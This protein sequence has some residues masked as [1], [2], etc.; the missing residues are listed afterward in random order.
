MSTLFIAKIC[1]C[2]FGKRFF[3]VA[4]TRVT[5]VSRQRATVLIYDQFQS[6]VKDQIVESRDTTVGPYSQRKLSV[7]TLITRSSLKFSKSQVRTSKI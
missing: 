3:A 5:T 2:Y 1:F 6:T 4:T 7:R